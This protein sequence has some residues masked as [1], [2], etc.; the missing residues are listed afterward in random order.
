MRQS[1][2]APLSDFRF[3]HQFFETRHDRAPSDS[4]VRPV[5]DLGPTLQSP[6]RRCM[7]RS[8]EGGG[9]DQPYGRERTL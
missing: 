9:R 8:R 4:R 6:T 3:P 2:N 1:V 5:P 7:R